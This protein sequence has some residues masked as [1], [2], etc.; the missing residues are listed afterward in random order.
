MPVG[1]HAIDVSPD[2]TRLNKV[3]GDGRPGTPYV[4][5]SAGRWIVTGDADTL[6]VGRTGRPTVRVKG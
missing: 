6:I 2:L 5:G 3:S 1:W 4:P